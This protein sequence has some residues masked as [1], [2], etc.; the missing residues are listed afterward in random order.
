MQVRR[1]SKCGFA[2]SRVYEVRDRNDGAVMRRRICPI[3]GRKW[4]TA[5]IR[6]WEYENLLPKEDEDHE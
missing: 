3:C 6:R 4:E 2:K 5:E 1:C